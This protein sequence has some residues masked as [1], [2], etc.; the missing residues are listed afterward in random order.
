MTQGRII[1]AFMC[2]CTGLFLH[3]DQHQVKHRR[4]TPLLTVTAEGSPV[5]GHG[6]VAGEALPQL[7]THTLVVAGVLRAGC[8]GT[9][10]MFPAD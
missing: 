4:N 1:Y 8:A 7:Q 9:C 5:G 2:V 6:A 10:R 3:G